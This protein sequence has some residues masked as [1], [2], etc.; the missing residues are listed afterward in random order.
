MPIVLKDAPAYLKAAIGLAV[1]AGFRK[2]TA[3]RVKKMPFAME[4]ST[5]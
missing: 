4:P 5:L 1:F 2:V 3:L